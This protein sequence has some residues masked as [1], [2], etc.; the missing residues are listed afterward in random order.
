MDAAPGSTLLRLLDGFSAE[1]ARVDARAADLIEEMDPRTTDE[2]L[3]AWLALY[4]VPDECSPLNPNPD[5]E[6]TQLLQ[7]VTVQ[8]SQNPAFYVAL[9]AAIGYAGAEVAE[10]PEFK[11]DQGSAGD[12]IHAPGWAHAFSVRTAD[13]AAYLRAGESAA[14]DMLGFYAAE[15]LKCLVLDARPAHSFAFIAASE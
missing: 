15:F 8:L 14:G 12:A 3:E 9:A 5:D 7:K 1:L 2:L 6:R 10:H 4:G 13:A 11:A